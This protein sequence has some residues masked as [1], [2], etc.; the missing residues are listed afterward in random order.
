V[1][2]A[3]CLSFLATAFLI[4]VLMGR[5]FDRQNHFIK[6]TIDIAGS[7]TPMRLNQDLVYAFGIESSKPGVT[8]IFCKNKVMFTARESLEELDRQIN[9]KRVGLLDILSG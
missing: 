5:L 2:H 9:R 4:G 3:V 7:W 6:A 1:T 8:I